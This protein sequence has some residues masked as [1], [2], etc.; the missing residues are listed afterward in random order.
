MKRTIS[1][2]N[3]LCGLLSTFHSVQILV[4]LYPKISISTTWLK[5]HISMSDVIPV[6]L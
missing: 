1:S 6:D 2:W 5:L 3:T 4:N